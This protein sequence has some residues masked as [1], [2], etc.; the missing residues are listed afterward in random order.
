[1]TPLVC[2]LFVR[3]LSFRFLSCIEEEE[4]YRPLQLLIHLQSINHKPSILFVHTEID[5]FNTDL[6]QEF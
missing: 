6:R 3:L 5:T 1:M 2:R 4:A